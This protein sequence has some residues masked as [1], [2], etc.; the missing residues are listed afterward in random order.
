QIEKSTSTITCRNMIR[1]KI[2][3]NRRVLLGFAEE[4]ADTSDGVNFNV[5]AALCELLAET[6]DVD[7]DSIG[8]DLARQPEDMI[9]DQLLRYDAILSPHQQLEHRGLAR[10]KDVRLVIDIGLPALGVERK[11][12]DLQRAAEQLAGSAQERR[13]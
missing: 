12:G 1:A 10:R 7:L 13:Q 5:G 8:G 11:I 9:L 4:V 6:M 3:L 2:D